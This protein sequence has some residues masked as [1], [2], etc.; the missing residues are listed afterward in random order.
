MATEKKEEKPLGIKKLICGSNGDISTSK[1][2][3]LFIY[4]ID[5][6]YLILDL[7]GYHSLSWENCTVLG[8]I[9]L[10]GYI[11]RQGSRS[12][13]SKWFNSLESLNIGSGGVSFTRDATSNDDDNS[14][15]EENNN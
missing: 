8:I 3:L 11:D 5:F 14:E 7:I 4:L 2:M 9:T 12:S 1:V 13:W 6:T 15:K 10:V